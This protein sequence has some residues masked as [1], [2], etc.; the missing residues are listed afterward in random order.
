[1]KAK[2]LNTIILLAGGLI[3]FNLLSNIIHFWQ[4]RGLLTEEEQK[5]EELQTQNL[6]LQAQLKYVQSEEFIEKSA[7]ENL[8]LAKPGEEVWV[9]PETIREIRES[10][11]IGEE[12]PNWE[13]WVELFVDIR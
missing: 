3:I 9:L 7:R 4:K 6:E 11:E 1:M 2:I 12:K 5:L 13:Q 10:R 8:G